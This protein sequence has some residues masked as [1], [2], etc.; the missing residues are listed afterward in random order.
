MASGLTIGGSSVFGTL[1]ILQVVTFTTTSGTATTSSTYQSTNLTA[2]ITP[3]LS[4]SKILILWTAD[5]QTANVS[6][7]GV[8]SLFRGATD[9]DTS[10]NGFGYVRYAGST[11]TVIHVPGSGMYYDSPATTSATTYTM[12][13]RSSDNVTNVVFGNGQMSIT[14]IEVAQ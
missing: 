14:L 2:S 11:T 12:K 4:T 6:A 1:P 10:T 8:Y 5:I 3:K 9:L 7:S 13:V